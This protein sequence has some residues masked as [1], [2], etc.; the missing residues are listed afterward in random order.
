MT[1]RTDWRGKYASLWFTSEQCEAIFRN[2]TELAHAVV[3]GQI[4]LAE[5]L[6]AAGEAG[7]RFAERAR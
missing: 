1:T 2:A 7:R 5:A 6:V 3:E 4:T